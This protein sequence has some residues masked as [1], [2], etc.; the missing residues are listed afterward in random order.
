MS[1]DKSNNIKSLHV[2]S[3]IRIIMGYSLFY[4]FHS[5]TFYFV[6]FRFHERKV[7]IEQQ[8]KG[9]NGFIVVIFPFNT[10]H[11]Q[12]AKGI[13]RAQ[14]YRSRKAIFPDAKCGWNEWVVYGGVWVRNGVFEKYHTWKLLHAII[15]INVAIN[16]MEI[17]FL[18]N[19]PKTHNSMVQMYVILLSCFGFFCSFLFLLLFV[20]L[21]SRKNSCCIFHFDA[22]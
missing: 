22:E 21:P 20:C 7:V 1:A 12:M 10:G 4:S 5:V 3:K 15:V 9:W 18:K 8:Q 16:S 19:N 6:P 17:R 14:L 13:I 2:I 11:G